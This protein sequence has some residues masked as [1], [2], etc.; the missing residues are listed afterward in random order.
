MKLLDATE[1]KL[2]RLDL[3]R[4]HQHPWVK[5]EVTEGTV[6]VASIIRAI[7]VQIG[8]FTKDDASD[9]IPLRMIVGMG[10]EAMCAQLYPTMQS[11]PG[12]LELDGISGHPD[13]ISTL[14][15]RYLIDEFKYT[16]KS[17]RVPG[18]KE[19]QWK[20]IRDEWIWQVQVMAY[21]YMLGQQYGE[22]VNLGR[23]HI[24][25][26]MG[27]YTKHTLDERYMRYLV[28]YDEDELERN[29]KM[30]IDNKPF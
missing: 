11:Q 28:E 1:I 15:S 24:C 14:G 6:G 3:P 16:A 26:A 8:K 23:L 21:C 20:D 5:Y 12:A 18:G 27:N 29:W 7:A 30:L 10:W 2:E 19:D 22:L 4:M 9:E 13:G 25:W 17:L